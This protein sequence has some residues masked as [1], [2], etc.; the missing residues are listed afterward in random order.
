MSAPRAAP[1]RSLVAPRA[2]RSLHAGAW[3]CTGKPGME[4]RRG[5]IGRPPAPPQL[6]ALLRLAG[7]TRTPVF[8]GL[9]AL[10]SLYPE[11]PSGAA[12]RSA[13]VSIKDK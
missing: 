6:P 2:W 5:R 11:P 3:G 13:L 4:R 9:Q 10:A 1:I 8:I 12:P 7:N